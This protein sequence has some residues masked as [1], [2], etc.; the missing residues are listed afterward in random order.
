MNYDVRYFIKIIFAMHLEL[1]KKK[2]Y[3]YIFKLFAYDI[4]TPPPCIYFRCR[5][6]THTVCFFFCSFDAQ[7]EIKLRENVL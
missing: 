6:E 2:L 3:A 7:K 5:K 1:H 4:L